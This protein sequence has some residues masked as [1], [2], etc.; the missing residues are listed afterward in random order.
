MIFFAIFVTPWFY[1][2]Q[3]TH[4]KAI[5][6]RRARQLHVKPSAAAAAPSITTLLT[7]TIVRPL[8]MLVTEP[9]VTFLSLYVGFNFS[10]LFSFFAAFPYV[11]STVYN[12][13]VIESGL[14]FLAIGIGCVLAIPTCLLCE[15]YLYRP[16]VTLSFSLGKKGIVSPEY[17]LYPAMMGS[18]AIPIG[19]FWFAWT[20]RPSISWGSPVCAAIPF[21][22]GN[23]C[24]FI[25][26]TN[27]LID[28]YGSGTGASAMAANGFMRYTLGAVFPLFTL[29]MYGG[30][31]VG[32]ASS[33]LGGIGILLMPVPWVLFKWGK[34]VRGRSGYDTLKD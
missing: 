33:L 30:L 23:L 1:F 9:I 28:T 2:T 22:W 27:Y 13:S 11:F 20:S 17:R 21:A 19:L 7:M 4:K 8:H 26:A 24:I 25:S 32:G 5:L 14:V 16:Q 34:Q 15:K 10:V 3:E 18:F 31:G 6:A 29:Q 12:F